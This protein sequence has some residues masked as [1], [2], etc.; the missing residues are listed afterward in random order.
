MNPKKRDPKRVDPLSGAEE[1]KSA[2]HDVEK[3]GGQKAN[4][5]NTVIP[6]TGEVIRDV[7]GKEIK[8]VT[9]T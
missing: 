7:H 4:A 1:S 2:T 8:R 6:G 3:R 9:N 5:T